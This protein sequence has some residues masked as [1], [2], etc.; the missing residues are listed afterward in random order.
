[1]KDTSTAIS[2]L[3]ALVSEIVDLRQAASLIGWDEHVTMPPG[4]VAAHGGMAATIQRIAHEQF[5]SP[6]LGSALED[7]AREAQSLPSDSEPARLVKVT[8]RDYDRAVRV[9]REFVAEQ[10][11]GRPR[12]HQ[13]W[14]EARAQSNYA[15][16]QPHLEKTVRLASN[17]RPF[18]AVSPPLRYADRYL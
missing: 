15:L 9:P 7:A 16:L 8:A 4:G 6:E 10:A 1:M 13:A 5:T 3:N 2:K 17:M 18:S 11:H 14:K 12:P